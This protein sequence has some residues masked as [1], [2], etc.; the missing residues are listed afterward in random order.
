MMVGG[1]VV[2]IWIWENDRVHV[3]V[4][5]NQKCLEVHLAKDAHSLT[6]V[7]GDSLWWQLGNAYWTPR[8]KSLSDVQIKRYGLSVPSDSCLCKARAALAKADK[9]E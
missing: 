2:D 1:I 8:D 3:V 7:R 4:K 5:E 6:I 9:E